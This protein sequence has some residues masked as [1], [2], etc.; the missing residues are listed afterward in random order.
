M[1]PCPDR[2]EELVAQAMQDPW[3]AD[4]PEFRAHV[5]QCPGCRAYVAQVAETLARLEGNGPALD[6]PPE[7]KERLLAQIRS[8]GEPAAPAGQAAGAQETSLARALRWLA[9]AVVALL[10]L[11][12]FLLAG[13]WR[14]QSQLDALTRLLEVGGSQMAVAYD[15]MGL[16][17][18]PSD[19][20]LELAPAEPAPAGP[21]SQ[22]AGRASLYQTESG[23]LVVVSVWDLPMLED[24]RHVYQVWLHDAGGRRNGGVFRVDPRGRG[25]LIYRAAGDL[26]VQAIGITREPDPYGE[27]PRGPQVLFAQLP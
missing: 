12:G 15:L 27:E 17:G 4:A 7:L 8:D 11:N 23:H 14:M 6:P 22:A 3:L 26:D 18:I 16:M 1:K 20:V 19:A 5:A 13:L 10:L 25:T 21:A 24:H 2:V 9:A